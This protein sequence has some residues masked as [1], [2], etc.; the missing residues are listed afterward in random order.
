MDIIREQGVAPEA[1]LRR[2]V[3]FYGADKVMWGSDIGTSSG[4][5]KEMVKRAVDST[6]LLDERE[7]REVLHDTGL[8]I[9]VGS[10]EMA[11]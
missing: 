4:T 11:A 5:Y 7:R 10:N 3:D 6:A 1:V 8:R 2:T 9:F